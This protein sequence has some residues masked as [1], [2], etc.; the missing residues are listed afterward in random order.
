[1]HILSVSNIIND[2]CL[3]IMK[4]LFKTMIVTF[5]QLAIKNTTICI[6]KKEKYSPLVALI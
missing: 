6:N 3:L 2:K 4:A 5:N 1:M